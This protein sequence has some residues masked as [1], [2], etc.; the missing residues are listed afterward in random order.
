M[1]LETVYGKDYDIGRLKATG[2]RFEE[3]FGG[4][5]RLFSSSGRI[6]ILGNHTDHNHGKVLVGAINLDILAAAAKR[7][8]GRIII[9]SEGFPDIELST[10]EFDN[11]RE[12]GKSVA[13]VRGILFKLNEMGYRPGGLSCVM[14]S[15]V[16]KGAGVSSSAAYEVLIAKIFSFLY[17]GDALTPLQLAKISQFAE[18]EYFG[19]PCGLLDQSGIAF[20]GVNYIDFENIDDPEVRTVNY[21]IKGYD[22]VITNT[23]GDHSDLTSEYASI[24]DDMHEVS[25][26]FGKKFLREVSYEQFKE[27]IP[28]LK[29][30]LGGRA[31]LR[32]IHFYEENIRVEKALEAVK[33]GDVE[34]FLECVNL[35][36][37][38]SY[39]LLQNCYPCGDREQGIPLALELSRQILKGSGAVRV[40]GGGFAGTIIAFVPEDLTREYIGQMS[41]VFGDGSA[42]KVSVR[43]VGATVLPN[44]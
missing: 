2:K 13:L 1:D 6:E 44:V 10:G 21:D 24:K 29:R 30:E 15:N 8:D 25:G 3:E 43:N 37:E 9:K 31:V 35:S 41:R 42:V 28:R 40:H 5:Y 33:G 27:N 7:N 11:R 19:K 20:G 23:G 18:R 14:T 32:A 17:C 36:G 4:E 38:S 22:I 34:K 39:K 16:F 26:R 12:C